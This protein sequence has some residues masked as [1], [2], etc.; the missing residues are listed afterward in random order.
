MAKSTPSGKPKNPAVYPYPGGGG[1]MVGRDKGKK[2]KA[3]DANCPNCGSY[4]QF[5]NKRGNKLGKDMSKE[6]NRGP[7]KGG[8]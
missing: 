7:R 3:K 5:A 8:K 4:G 6:F 1:E 2:T